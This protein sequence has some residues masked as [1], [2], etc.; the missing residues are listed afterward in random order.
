M[1]RV[2]VSSSA[3]ADPSKWIARA[4]SALT[5]RSSR[6]RWTVLIGDLALVLCQRRLGCR[7]HGWEVY[8]RIDSRDASKLVPAASLLSRDMDLHLLLYRNSQSHHRLQDVANPLSPT[9]NLPLARACWS[10]WTLLR[11][12][13]GPADKVTTARQVSC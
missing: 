8:F 1:S 3:Y 7:A 6:P 12:V 4:T 10:R 13:K 5:Q 11:A 9:N 2:P